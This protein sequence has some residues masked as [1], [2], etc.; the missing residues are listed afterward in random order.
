MPAARYRSDHTAQIRRRVAGLAMNACIG[1]VF[2]A[3]A[4]G[5]LVL[6][7]WRFEGEPAVLWQVVWIAD[8]VLGGV[9][10]LTLAAAGVMWLVYRRRRAELDAAGA[11]LDGERKMRAVMRRWDDAD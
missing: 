6:L 4:A 9:S 7:R 10:L 5:V 1:L 3:V 8:A 11:E 2:T